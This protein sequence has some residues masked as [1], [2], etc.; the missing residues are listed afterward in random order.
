M[1]GGCARPAWNAPGNLGCS[2]SDFRHVHQEV[3]HDSDWSTA[4]LTS[5]IRKYGNYVGK[6][7]V[8][9]L[10][11]PSSR[12]VLQMCGTV[13]YHELGVA[14]WKCR[15]ESLSSCRNEPQPCCFRLVT[16]AGRCALFRFLCERSCIKIGSH[17]SWQGF[18]L[19]WVLNTPTIAMRKRC[20]SR[21][22][23]GTTGSVARKRF[24]ANP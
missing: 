23:L 6:V 1:H 3:V 10:T 7:L 15:I 12:A 22:L 8:Y 14:M 13:D 2:K 21:A 9:F 17:F 16:F 11:T 24:T 4:W 5:L 18:V 19:G 20:P